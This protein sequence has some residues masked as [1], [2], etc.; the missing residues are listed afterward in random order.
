MK[1]ARRY[2]LA[3]WALLC[4]CA[5]EEGGQSD[6]AAIEARP[7]EPSGAPAVESGP[8]GPDPTP[9]AN[10]SGGQS[11][12][13]AG[14]PDSVAG[15]APASDPAPVGGNGGTA[16]EGVAGIGA[17]GSAGQA[18][19][20]AGD[21]FPEDVTAPRIMIVG[22]SISAGPGCYK[23]YLLEQLESNGYSRF[24]FVGEYDDDCGGGV[25]HSAVSCTTAG[26]YTMPT[27]MVTNCFPDAF[28][29][30]ATLMSNHNP[31]LVMIQLGVNDV[32]GGNTPVELVLANYTTLIE[33]ARAH[34]PNVVL[35]VAQ[36]HKI[37]TDN[38]SNTA[39][40]TNA[41]QLVEA[42]PAWAAG[43]TTDA[44]PVFVA[45]LWTNS[46]PMEADD[47]VHPDDAGARRMGQ[48]WFT[49][50]ADILPRD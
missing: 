35:V 16:F 39:S 2:V 24:E 32:W 49:A 30:L 12:D 9:V 8:S 15:E 22:D 18:P 19:L 23:K 21:I 37:I 6:A 4:A 47:C 42:V 41:Q 1:R 25:R 11:G 34:N 31:D 29:G 7:P 44:S 38:C 27:F 13:V 43:L 50:L 28:P 10:G 20:D 48:N 14:A 33:Q 17:S 36:I 40:T 45:D 5:G 26:N 46:D 3:P